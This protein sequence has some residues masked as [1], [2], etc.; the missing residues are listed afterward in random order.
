ME[1]GVASRGCVSQ[2]MCVITALALGNL[3]GRSI[4]LRAFECL[5]IVCNVDDQGV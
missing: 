5:L 2:G 4:F 3:K 1:F